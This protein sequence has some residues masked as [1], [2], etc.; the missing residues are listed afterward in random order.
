M[1]ISEISKGNLDDVKNTLQMFV[2]IT[3]HLLA[4]GV[5]QWN[6]DYP[7]LDTL[8]K[9]AESGNNFVI[10]AGNEIAASIALDP[11]QDEQYQKIHWRHRNE[12]V[13]VIH[14]L[15]VHPSF[16]GRGLGKKMCLFAE[17]YAK[18]NWYKFIRLDAYAGNPISKKLYLSLG[19][20]Q[21]NGYC[22]FRKKAIP[23]FCYEKV[24]S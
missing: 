1:L 5:N 6:Y 23:F 12:K 15:G 17:Q 8:T 9:D 18:D 20:T 16:Q 14:R 24:I 13:L 3:D 21:A 2:A 4:A 22:Y 19:Y 7:D 10:R 11:Y